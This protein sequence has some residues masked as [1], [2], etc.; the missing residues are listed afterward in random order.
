[1]FGEGHDTVPPAVKKSLKFADKHYFSV[2]EG[3]F[4][5]ISITDFTRPFRKLSDS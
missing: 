1:M 4:F 2:F 5:L 3:F